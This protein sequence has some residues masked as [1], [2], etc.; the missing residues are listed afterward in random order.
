LLSVEPEPSSTTSIFH[1]PLGAFC[2]LRHTAPCAL[3]FGI[4]YGP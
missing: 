3:T 4:V 1:V 2:T